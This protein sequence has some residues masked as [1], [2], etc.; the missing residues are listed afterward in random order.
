[1]TGADE[2]LPPNGER[3]HAGETWPHDRRD[4]NVNI[5]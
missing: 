1:M 5:D 3:I 2:R 4:N